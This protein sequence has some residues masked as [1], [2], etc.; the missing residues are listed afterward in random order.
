MIVEKQSIPVVLDEKGEP[1]AIVFF[2]KNMD[3]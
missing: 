2:N 3:Y 1:V